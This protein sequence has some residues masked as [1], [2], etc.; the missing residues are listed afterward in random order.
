[1][2]PDYE[3]AYH[4]LM[5]Y[6]DCIPEEERHVVDQSLRIALG[7]GEP[8]TAD[9]FNSKW[10]RDKQTECS[11]GSNNAQI[12]TLEAVSQESGGVPH[13]KIKEAL[14]RLKDQFGYGVP[15]EKDS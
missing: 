5:H 4:I 6:W 10:F 11:M 13:H 9:E 3:T 8:S 1:M 2:K 12:G 7:E 15:D 14:K